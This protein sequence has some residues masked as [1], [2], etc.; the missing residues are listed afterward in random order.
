MALESLLNLLTDSKMSDEDKR[1]AKSIRVLIRK[2]A[3]DRVPDLQ[4]FLDKLVQ[5]SR[6][7]LEE[8]FVEL[9][10]K[11]KLQG[12]EADIEAF[13]KFKRMRNI[14][15]HGVDE[16]V[17]QQVTVTEKEVRT[18]S[19]L[20]EQYVNWVLFRDSNVYRSRWRP[21]RPTETADNGVKGSTSE[22]KR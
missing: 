5:H 14:L 21:P 15:V 13:R 20:V 18:L 10:T 16:T 22:L 1:R 8:T 7:T 6:P 3:C 19:D 12:W 9:A 17:Q 11:A 4:D 2:H